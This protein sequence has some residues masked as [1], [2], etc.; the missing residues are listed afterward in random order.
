MKIHSE[1]LGTQEIDPDSIIHFPSG[2]AGL[3]DRH[4]FKLFHEAGKTT[5]FWLQSLDDDALSF[6]I[7]APEQLSVSYEIRL[8]DEECEALQLARPE[9]VAILLILNR[10]EPEEGSADVRANL[11]GPL[12]INLAARR[13]I[14]KV[15]VKPE[16][17]LLLR[18]L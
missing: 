10:P 9:D 14:Q 2:L 12:I 3:E 18:A 8:G 4:D 16:R 7:C 6:S 1:F 5:V 17:Q 11:H 13:G 15:L